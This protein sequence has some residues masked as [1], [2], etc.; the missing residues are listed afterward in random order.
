MEEALARGFMELMNPQER[1]LFTTTDLTPAEIFGIP[2]LIAYAKIFGSQITK[3][4]IENFCLMRISRLR[5]GRKEIM[6]S[7]T[8]MRES[9]EMQK[10]KG[11]MSDFYAGL[12]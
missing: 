9:M 1:K 12:K 5:L 3:D 11:K 7:M 8:G 2:T 10:A 6:I 4:W